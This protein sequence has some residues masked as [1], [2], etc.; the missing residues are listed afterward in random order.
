[1]ALS[2]NELLVNDVLIGKSAGGSAGQVAEAINAKSAEHGV[3]ASAKNEVR[4]DIDLANI[5][6]TSAGF[7]INGNAVDLTTSNTLSDIVN[8]I[9]TKNVGDVRAS[10]NAN[11]QLVLSSASGQ[12]IK[13]EN[14]TS[15]VLLDVILT[16]MEQKVLK[17]F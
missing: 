8:E 9:N 6:G 15:L 2:D 10:A 5:P 12:D 17:V 11:G 7:A 1:M 4:L 14:M 3:T 13:V 16:S